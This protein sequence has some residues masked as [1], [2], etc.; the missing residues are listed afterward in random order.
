MARIT[1]EDCSV[2]I[3]NRFEL[4]VLAAHRARELSSGDRPRV[5]RDHDKN[6]LVSLR[7]IA[8]GA[9]SAGELRERM[10]ESM[11]RPVVP[12]ASPDEAVVAELSSVV[13]TEETGDDEEKG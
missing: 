6:T 8:D 11:A 9:V 5:A 12:P 3:P 4:I 10:S 1:V 13:I 2:R 7:E